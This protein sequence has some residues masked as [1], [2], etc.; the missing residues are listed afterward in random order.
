M[1]KL[2]ATECLDRVRTIEDNILTLRVAL[3]R[4]A[5]EGCEAWEAETLRKLAD[6]QMKL[7]GLR[8]IYPR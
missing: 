2:S 6:A 5:H 7:Y 8:R 4:Q 1:G 3:G